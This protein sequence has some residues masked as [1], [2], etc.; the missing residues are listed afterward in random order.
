MNRSGQSAACPPFLV[1]RL[2]LVTRTDGSAV[3]QDEAEPHDMR[4]EAEPR[5]EK[6]TADTLRFVRPTN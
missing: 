5:N 4:Y 1:T 2:C 6:K 3:R